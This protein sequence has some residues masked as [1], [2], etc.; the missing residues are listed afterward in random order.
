MGRSV[1]VPRHAED[2]AY[3][4]FEC[5]EGDE[6]H[7]EFN[8]AVSELQ[9]A[10][11]AKYTS[12]RKADRW[13][14]NEDHVVLENARYCITISEYCGLVAIAAVPRDPDNAL[15]RHSASQVKL[16]LFV[17]AF[18]GTRL[19]SKGTASNG[20]QFFTPV[21][22]SENKGALGLGFTSKEGWL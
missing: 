10:A 11:M 19:I 18:G 20:E 12:L 5:D 22:K 1:S 7:Y 8:E 14:G 6:Y 3:T 17:E 21:A 2:V 16:E 15:D 4:A 9:H 13:L